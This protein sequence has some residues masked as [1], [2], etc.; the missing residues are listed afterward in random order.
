VLQLAKIGGACDIIN[1]LLIENLSLIETVG[2]YWRQIVNRWRPKPRD[3]CI[4]KLCY[5]EPQTL[6]E[7]LNKHGLC[8][9]ELVYI[10][11][12]YPKN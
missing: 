2:P 3:H 5:I 8:S 11:L 6:A 9:M 10:S 12:L 7:P 1:I 4:T